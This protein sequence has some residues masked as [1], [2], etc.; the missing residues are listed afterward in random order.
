MHGHNSARMHPID[1]IFSEKLLR[2]GSDFFPNFHNSRILISLICIR[3]Q[4]FLGY[5][6]VLLWFFFA[7][8]LLVIPADVTCFNL[9]YYHTHFENM[10]RLN[11][12][13]TRAVHR[14]GSWTLPFL[15][16][17]RH[18]GPVCANRV[19]P[20]PQIWNGN[21]CAHHTHCVV[22]RISVPHP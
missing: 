13:G 4:W 22:F 19:W 20:G 18:T 9:E 21:S 1:F 14:G 12:I 8:C 6:A 5:M 3:K 2:H 10:M 7:L 15:S 16:I 17:F 11:L